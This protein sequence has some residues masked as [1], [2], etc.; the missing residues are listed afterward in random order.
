[1]T[2]FNIEVND[3]TVNTARR[4]NLN[5][6]KTSF[7]RITKQE[8][9]LTCYKAEKTSEMKE[10][11]EA[12]RKTFSELYLNLPQAAKDNM[13]HSDKKWFTLD[14]ACNKQNDQRYGTRMKNGVGGRPA[15]F[16]LV[17]FNEFQ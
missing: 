11:D 8:L 4:N 2:D 9:G 15:N 17:S 10:G 3:N 16:R 6:K 7:K 5:I 12:P 1:M 14:G 13:C